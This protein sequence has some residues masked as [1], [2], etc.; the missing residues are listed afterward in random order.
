MEITMKKGSIFNDD[1]KGIHYTFT[2]DVTFRSKEEM[3]EYFLKNVHGK[4]QST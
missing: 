2:E 3:N 1:S 4:T